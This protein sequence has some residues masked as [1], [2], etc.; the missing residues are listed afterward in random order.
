MRIVENH[1]NSARENKK[2]LQAGEVG[3]E[4]GVN[5]PPAQEGVKGVFFYLASNC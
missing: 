4:I 1:A 3:N 2:S 5:P